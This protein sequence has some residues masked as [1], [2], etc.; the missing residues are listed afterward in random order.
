[1]NRQCLNQRI[2]GWE[3]L[4][5]ELA[6]WE[7]RRNSDKASINW[8]FDVKAAREKFTRA[9]AALGSDCN[10]S[11]M[12]ELLCLGTSTTRPKYPVK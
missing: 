1:M 5:N 11:K 10:R 3:Q 12:S 4:H 9:Y 2:P 7:A 6:A 8:Q